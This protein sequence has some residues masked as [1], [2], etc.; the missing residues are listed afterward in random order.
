MDGVEQDALNIFATKA[1]SL[2]LTATRLPFPGGPVSDSRAGI[3]PTAA[4]RYQM[5]A[6]SPGEGPLHLLLNGHMDVVPAE[7][8]SLWTSPPFQPEIRDGRMYG[9]GAADMKSGFAVGMLA[10][11][12]LRDTVPDL[13]SHQR[14]GFVAVV[15]EECSGNGTLI[16]ARQ[17][18][19]APEVVVLEPGL[20]SSFIYKP[21]WRCG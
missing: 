12:A 3:A 17:G 11:A 14:I 20:F 16:A 10:L 1:E 7:T 8:P 18:A 19:I 4:D 2:G 21:I 13:F 6:T 15:E 5:L 9:R